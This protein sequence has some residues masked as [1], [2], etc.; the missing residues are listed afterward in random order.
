MTAYVPASTHNVLPPPPSPLHSRT[1]H[2]SCDVLLGHL[3]QLDGVHVL[4]LQQPHEVLVR[5]AGL[6]VVTDN[7]HL[8]HPTP[9]QVSGHLVS[10]YLLI[11][12]ARL[13]G[14]GEG[15]E[16]GDG[17]E[18]GE[19]KEGSGRGGEGRQREGR[20][21]RGREGRGREG[22]QG[23]GRE[24]EERGGEGER[25]EGRGGEGRGQGR[26][27]RGDDRGRGEGMTGGG[28]VTSVWRFD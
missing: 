13:D 9:L 3:G 18:G 22:R 16:G 17:R 2:Q 1:E 19:G 11:E 26:G 27:G 7:P 5:G 24:G 28:E 4:G 8:E 25:R 20:G 10:S 23:D 12:G 21:G 14:R 6:Q 15:R